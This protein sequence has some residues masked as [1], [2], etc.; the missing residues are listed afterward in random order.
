MI[1]HATRIKERKRSDVV[2]FTRGRR[3][4]SQKDNISVYA[5]RGRSQRFVTSCI[6][7]Y[8]A[9]PQS[10]HVAAAAAAFYQIPSPR[11]RPTNWDQLPRVCWMFHQRR[12]HEAPQRLLSSPSLSSFSISSSQYLLALHSEGIDYRS[13]KGG[14]LLANGRKNLP[15]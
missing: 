7:V 13:S 1:G 14:Q 2:A 9:S 4:P 8:Q 11:T 10:S 6:W 3:C 5:V 15:R 12:I